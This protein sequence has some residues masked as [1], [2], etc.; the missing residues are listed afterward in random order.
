MIRWV[1][2]QLLLKVEWATN[3]QLAAKQSIEYHALQR[4]VW[5]WIEMQPS[6]IFL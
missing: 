2:V 3:L 4:A 1:G 6:V 5:W